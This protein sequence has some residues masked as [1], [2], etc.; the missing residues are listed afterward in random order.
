MPPATQSALHDLFLSEEKL[1]RELDDA[2]TPGR[3]DDP[4][5]PTL[6]KVSVTEVISRRTEVHVV[7][8]IKELRA[9]LQFHLLPDGEI[10]D[11]AEVGLEKPGS[12][13]SVLPG[14][15]E[16]SDGVG[17]EFRGIE[18]TCDQHTVR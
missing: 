17:H 9:E 8:E 4:K 6:R 11:R 15:A 7:E 3:C 14:V 2:R 10:L 16:R 1:E 12:P 18:V 13:E 5:V